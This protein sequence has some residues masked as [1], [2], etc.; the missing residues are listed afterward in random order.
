M[1][2]C[3][4]KPPLSGHPSPLTTM[5][6]IQVRK[7]S[8]QKPFRNISRKLGYLAG[9]CKFEFLL[10]TSGCYFKP[11]ERS[12]Y[13]VTVNQ[14]YSM[15]LFIYAAHIFSSPKTAKSRMLMNTGN[16]LSQSSEHIFRVLFPSS[17]KIPAY[18]NA[19][20]YEKDK[21]KN[22]FSPLNV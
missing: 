8:E 17:I 12:K 16:I 1:Y 11:N 3:R 2:S 13:E 20:N 6:R 9:V 19:N 22:L 18:R 5:Q 10:M 15:H 7:E 4:S 14:L 21:E